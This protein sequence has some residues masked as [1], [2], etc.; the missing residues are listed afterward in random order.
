MLAR[1]DAFILDRVFQPLANRFSERLSPLILGAVLMET[2]GLMLLV[3]AF[4]GQRPWWVAALV[5]PCFVII[6]S[7]IRYEDRQLRLGMLNPL[8]LD[9][10]FNRRLTLLMLPLEVVAGSYLPLPLLTLGSAWFFA[11]C[12]KLPPP[13]L[14]KEPQH[15]AH[16]R[17][18]T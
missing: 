8:R 4:R 16:A 13:Q 17:L 14:R 1:L 9:Y 12:Q 3:M 18:Q 7:R 11:S 2:T 6:T 15:E 5:L 10:A